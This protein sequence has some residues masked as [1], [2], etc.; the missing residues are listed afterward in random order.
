VDARTLAWTNR[1]GVT[2]TLTATGE[3][4]RF[5]TGTDYPYADTPYRSA[6]V[7]FSDDD[8]YGGWV[9]QITGPGGEPY[10]RLSQARW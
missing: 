3:P 1:A 5:E 8:P 2:W 4:V 7:A 9:A 6:S 10:D